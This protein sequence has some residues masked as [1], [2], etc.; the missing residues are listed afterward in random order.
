MRLEQFD[1][2]QS[3]VNELIEQYRETKFTVNRLKKENQTLKKK[4]E[5]CSDQGID[6]KKITEIEHENEKLKRKQNVV[7]QQLKQLLE[8]LELSYSK[9]SGVD[10]LEKE[11]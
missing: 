6:P 10:S 1:K 5:L 4:L 8:Q 9:Q 3:L 2:L 7:S 11:S